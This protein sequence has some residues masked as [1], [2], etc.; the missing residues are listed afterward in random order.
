[1]CKGLHVVNE[2]TNLLPTLEESGSK[3][4]HFITEIRN[5]KKLLDHRQTSKLLD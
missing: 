5:F 4:S 3:V 2:V 1:M